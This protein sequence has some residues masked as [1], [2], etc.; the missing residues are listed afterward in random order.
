MSEMS[1]ADLTAAVRDAAVEGLNLAA[2]RVRAVA[3]PRTPL[4]YGDLRS[5]HTVVP[6]TPDHLESA[7]VNDLEY[8][9]KQH[10]D[11]TLRHDDGQAKYLESAA[12]ESA[13]EI[14][15]LMAAAL[16]RRLGG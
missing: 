11:L 5:A 16:R 2:E 15:Q 8:A 3:V 7:V 10:E 14:E 13:A 4:E 1:A 9:V 12:I 6:A